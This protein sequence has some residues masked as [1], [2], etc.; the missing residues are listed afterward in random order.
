MQWPDS[1]LTL[2]LGFVDIEVFR[3]ATM[4]QYLALQVIYNGVVLSQ[5]VLGIPW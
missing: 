4:F 3:E 5:N 1:Y 2:A